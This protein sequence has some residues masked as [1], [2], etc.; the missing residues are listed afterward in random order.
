MAI[1]QKIPKLNTAKDKGGNKEWLMK[2]FY[3][4]EY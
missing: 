3:L 1:C 2:P 4:R